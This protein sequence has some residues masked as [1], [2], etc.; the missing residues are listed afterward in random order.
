M[1]NLQQDLGIGIA[2]SIHAGARSDSVETYVIGCLSAAAEAY[3]ATI[4]QPPERRG[5]TA[6]RALYQRA[7]MGERLDDARAIE[8][9]AQEAASQA[10]RAAMPTIT[11]RRMAQAYIACACAGLAA[12]YLTGQD[13]RAML[14]GAQ[15]ALAAHPQRRATRGRKS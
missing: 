11:N 15:L 3:A 7:S 6:M 2:L 13:A 1:T 5:S 8:E 12:K 9:A 10:F 14:Y 4:E